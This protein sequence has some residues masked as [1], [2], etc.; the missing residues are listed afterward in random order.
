[1]TNNDKEFLVSKIR[2]Q[3][4]A[5][6]PGLIDDLKALDKKVKLPPTAFAYT[7]GGLG[8]LVLG[9]GMSLV[10]TEIGSILGLASVTV[11]GIAIGTVGLLMVLVNY[12]IYRAILKSRKEKYAAKILKLSDEIMKQK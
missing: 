1:M 8:A 11:P 9:S 3:Y 2:T 6:T 5:K 10:M 12:P 7:F 4:T